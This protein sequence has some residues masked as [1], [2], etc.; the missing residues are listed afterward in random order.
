MGAVLAA[1]ALMPAP[2]LRADPI[3]VVNALRME[4]CG[5]QAAVGTRVLPH[6]AL[7]DVARELSRDEE[8]EAAFE[9]AGYPAASA[10]SFHTTGSRNDADIRRMLAARH[11]RALGDPRY[12]E[13]GAFE[14][15][16]ETWIVLA[17]RRPPPPPPLQTA[18][19]ERQVLALVNA[20]RARARD[21]GRDR[22][23]AA[24]A[25][26]L[27]P[28]LNAAALGHARDM[29]A[30]GSLGH[31]GS[32]G[33]RSGDRISRAGYAWQASG[34]N[35]AAGQRDADAVVAAWLGSPGHCAT[36]MGPHFTEMGIA[37]SLAPSENPDI[38]WTQ[39]FAAPSADNQ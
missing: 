9:R 15:G 12:D 16:D 6:P 34:E 22:Y 25:L 4:G 3:G 36:L 39:V 23:Q 11:C 24:Q 29:A 35:V 26:T 32:D 27:S 30:R 2:A 5:E 21:C 8:L 31:D 20:A 13:I 1:G 33:S 18:A 7:F 37:F 17:V 38:Y 28:T 10:A 19:V 14:L